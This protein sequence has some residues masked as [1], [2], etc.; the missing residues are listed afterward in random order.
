MW[1][2]AA[3]ELGH[4]RAVQPGMAEGVVEPAPGAF[5]PGTEIARSLGSS[6]FPVALAANFAA[7]GHRCRHLG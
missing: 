6:P 1:R 4:V 3:V 5:G 2:I 7:T